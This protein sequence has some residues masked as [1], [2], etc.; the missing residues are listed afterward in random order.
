MKDLPTLPDDR[1]PA[2]VAE[3][4][5][6]HKP[7]TWIKL[8]ALVNVTEILAI[9]EALSEQRAEAAPKRDRPAKKR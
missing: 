3:L 2:V 9:A 6:L 1:P 7:A 5:L 8:I 4:L